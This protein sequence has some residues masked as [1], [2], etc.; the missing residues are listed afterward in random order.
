MKV[1]KIENKFGNTFLVPLF[2]AKAMQLNEEIVSF[3]I[4]EV[5]HVA[6]LQKPQTQTE[7]ERSMQGQTTSAA[8]LENQALRDQI[9][10]LKQK[11]T[12]VSKAPV[13]SDEIKI[14]EAAPKNKGGRPALN[15]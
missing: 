9:D 15:K 6:N 8:E 4:V 5:D 12:L 13:V 14:P 7:F 11:D 3:D 1:A 10:L 2:R